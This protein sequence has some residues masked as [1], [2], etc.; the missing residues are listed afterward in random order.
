MPKR[1]GIPRLYQKTILSNGVRVTTEHI[2]YVRSVTIGF[3][4]RTGS[5]DEDKERNGI[6]HFIEHMLFKGTSSRSARQIAE[7][8]DAAGGQLNA[9]TSKEHT[10]YYVRVL[11]EHL[12]LAVE[13]LSDMVLDSQFNPIEV[14]KEK[15]VILEEI[16]MYEDS[17]DELVHDLFADAVLANHP[18]GKGILGQEETVSALDRTALL[19][20]MSD[21]YT[22]GNLVVAAAGNVT[23]EQVVEAVQRHLDRLQGNGTLLSSPVDPPKGRSVIRSK[24]TEQVHLCIGGLGVSRCSSWKYPLYVLD[25]ALGGGMSSRLFQELREER[26]LVYATYSYHTLFQETGLFT[27]YAGCGPKNV[28]Q[29]MR[30]VRQECAG[31][32]KDGLDTLELHRA[33][34]QLKGSL[35]LSLENTAN[36]MSRLA[37]SE[38]FQEEMVTADE[39]MSRIEAVTAEQVHTIA[40]EL[41]DPKKQ[42]IAAIG[43]VSATTLEVD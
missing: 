5:R 6:S 25:M 8:I 10:C 14:E 30:L 7:T 22:A 32:S 11:D 40:E 37:K 29:V 39:L 12:D 23:H 16:R 35:M 26:G 20:Y 24:D 17:P 27:I 38:L 18:L 42:V 19:S 36:R 43:P 34:E 4:F 3:W 9:F 21:H 28:N 13:I 41:L 1:G 33:K 2:P 31:L 15:A